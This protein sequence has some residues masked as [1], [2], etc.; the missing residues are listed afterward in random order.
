[1]AMIGRSVFL[2]TLFACAL[3]G[4]AGHAR[5]P[6]APVAK[7]SIP[8]GMLVSLGGNDLLV[9]NRDGQAQVLR[10]G[11]SWQPETRLPLASVRQV[12]VQGSRVLAVG[13]DA[14][15]EPVALQLTAALAPDAQWKLPQEWFEIGEGATSPW[16][17]SEK[18]S[19]ALSP[20]GVLGA[21][22]ALPAPSGAKSSSGT[23]YGYRSESG[24]V[25]CQGEDKT[26]ANAAS[27]WCASQGSAAWQLEGRFRDPLVCGAFLVLRTQQAQKTEVAVHAL[28]SG[29]VV[30]KALVAGRPQLACNEG[31]E[32]V[33]GTTVIEAKSLPGLEPAWKVKAKGPV[34]AMA[35]L[36][37][38]IAYQ[39]S[40]SDQVQLVARPKP[41]AK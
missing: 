34:A 27:A 9:W 24:V 15:R 28:A 8:N 1:M 33:I 12:R 6:A 13:F 36:D 22:A 31:R 25:A 30:A 40:G 11:T 18:G 35:V 20:N 10:G 17:L 7:T 37:D 29:A 16:L 14:E 3:G 2:S 32:I 38:W 39:K 5:P 21:R 26:L 4:S 19:L 41:S 23:L